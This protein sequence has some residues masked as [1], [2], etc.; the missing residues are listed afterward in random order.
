MKLYYT[1]GEVAEMLKVNTSLLRFWETE[2]PQLRPSKNSHGSR[3]YTE[4][5][6][7]LVKRIYHLTKE[8]GYTLDGA[9]EQLKRRRKTDVVSEDMVSEDVLQN[10]TA[11]TTLFPD[12]ELQQ[13]KDDLTKLQLQHTAAVGR[14]REARQQ[15]QELKDSFVED[16]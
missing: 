13:V 2:F 5:D 15:L 8:C 7:E 6:I 4:K 14:L 9:R 10:Q 3:T 11:A 1:I 12:L 16:V